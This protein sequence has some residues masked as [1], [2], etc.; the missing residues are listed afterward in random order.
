MDDQMVGM[1][2][3]SHHTHHAIRKENMPISI[4]LHHRPRASLPHYAF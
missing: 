1:R 3:T 2:A 4:S